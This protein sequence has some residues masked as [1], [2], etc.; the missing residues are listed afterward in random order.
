MH[1][2]AYNNHD[3]SIGMVTAVVLQLIQ[4]STDLPKKHGKRKAI[5]RQNSKWNEHWET[6]VS[7]CDNFLQNFYSKLRDIEIDLPGMVIKYESLSAPEN[8]S[9]RSAFKR[10]LPAPQT[11]RT[12]IRSFFE[13]FVHDLLKMVNR[14]EWPASVLLLEQLSAMLAKRISDENT[15]HPMRMLALKYLGTITARMRSFT[16]ESRHCNKPALDSLM[17]VVRGEQ[18]RIDHIQ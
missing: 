1:K 8:R 11:D 12:D 15:Q 4:S 18:V 5:V 2:L 3:G 6:A 17:E 10:L 13:N 7:F 9:K 16:I 14:P